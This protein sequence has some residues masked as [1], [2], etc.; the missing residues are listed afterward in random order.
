VILGAVILNEPFTARSAVATA[1][2]V[3][4]VILILRRA[5][6]R[7]TSPATE[8]KAPDEVCA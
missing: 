1:A 8:L 7:P 5:A 4:S 6:P 3:A 2:V